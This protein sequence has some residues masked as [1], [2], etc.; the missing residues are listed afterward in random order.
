VPERLNPTPHQRATNGWGY[1]LRLGRKVY[2]A[3]VVPECFVKL[4]WTRKAYI[5]MLEVFPQLVAFVNFATHLPQSIMAFID[6]TA[7]Q[8]V[9][10]KGYGK[11]TVINDMI[12]AFW[13][14]AAYHGWFVEFEGVPCKANVADAVS[15]DDCGRARCEGWTRDHSPHDEILRIFANAV[16]DSAI[17]SSPPRRRPTNFSWQRKASRV[18]PAR[19]GEAVRAAGADCPGPGLPFQRVSSCY[20]ANTTR[21]REVCRVSTVLVQHRSQCTACCVAHVCAQ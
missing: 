1:V 15:R 14:L 16:G 2:Y 7:G 17:W 11:D 20:R 21:R 9:F 5:Y 19:C 18:E 13:S 6:N 4:F 3:G 12:S 8:A 10:S